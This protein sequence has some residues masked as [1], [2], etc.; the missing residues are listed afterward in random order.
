MVN[1]VNFKWQIIKNILNEISNIKRISK[2]L[3]TKVN[4]LAQTE[5]CCSLTPRST[6][7]KINQMSIALQLAQIYN[8]L[9]KSN[10]K[11]SAFDS[12]SYPGGD[13][14]LKKGGDDENSGKSARQQCL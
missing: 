8:T 6:S 10:Q 14:K 9:Y 13:E 1:S 12:N 11:P 2:W 7:S 4:Q 5:T 3:T